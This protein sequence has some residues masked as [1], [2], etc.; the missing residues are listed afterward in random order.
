MNSSNHGEVIKSLLI[1][2]ELFK[3]LKMVPGV[4]MCDTELAVAFC[5]AEDFGNAYSHAIR[6]LHVAQLMQD[7]VMLACAALRLGQASNGREECEI[8]NGELE[9]AYY[10]VVRCYSYEMN[11][12]LIIEYPV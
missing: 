8:A 12:K 3:A 6:A 11:W 9:Q 5:R 1:A 2:R 10:A 7:R 4:G